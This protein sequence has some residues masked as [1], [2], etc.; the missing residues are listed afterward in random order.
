MYFQPIGLKHLTALFERF[1]EEKQHS[2]RV[3]KLCAA[4][5]KQLGL[6]RQELDLL[7]KA[8]IMHDIGKIALNGDILAK[9]DVLTEAEWIEVKRHSITGYQI[10]NSS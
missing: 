4:I 3:G 1:P 10:L 5:G 8:G 9:P 7:R 6:D 2:E